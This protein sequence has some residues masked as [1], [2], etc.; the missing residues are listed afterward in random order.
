MSSLQPVDLSSFK[1]KAGLTKRKMRRF[2]TGLENNIPKALDKKIAALEEEVWKEVDC[3]SC[4]NCCKSMTPTF[5]RQDIKRISAHFNMTEEA[6]Q[7]KWLHRERGGDWD[8]LNKTEPCQFL[9]LKTNMC[10]IYDIRPAD[11]AGYPHLHKKFRDY[12]HVYKQ[13]LELCPATHR[14]V[15]MMMERAKVN[16]Q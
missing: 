13:N 5:N 4:A 12:S 16:G 11:C 8:W 7:Q 1:Q 10:S 2:L 6:F 14:L 3:L 15:E 9:D